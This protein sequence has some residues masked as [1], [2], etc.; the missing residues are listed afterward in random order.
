MAVKKIHPFLDD[1]NHAD[2]KSFRN[3][4][5][6]LTQIRHRNIV[7][8]YGFCSTTR[9]KLLVYDFMERGSLASVLE[10]E[11]LDWERGVSLIKNVAHALSSLSLRLRTM[12]V[13]EKTVLVW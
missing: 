2:V 3:E 13:T 1:E 8:L 10:T 7:K 5:Q 11:E 12:R 4:V 6:A 9:C